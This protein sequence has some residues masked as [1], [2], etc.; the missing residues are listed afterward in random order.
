MLHL[1]E[2]PPSRAAASCAARKQFAPAIGKGVL[3]LHSR[4]HPTSHLCY[5]HLRC[6]N[7]HRHRRCFR[8][9]SRR[10][11]YVAAGHQ[12]TITPS[13]QPLQVSRPPPHPPL[14]KKQLRRRCK[15]EQKPLTPP[16]SGAPAVSLGDPAARPHR[17]S[18]GSTPTGSRS[19]CC[20]SSCTERRELPVP[21]P[22]YQGS[23]GD[24]MPP[25][26]SA[27]TKHTYTLERERDLDPP[28]SGVPSLTHF[29]RSIHHTEPGIMSSTIC[30]RAITL[31]CFMLRTAMTA[32]LVDD[33][34]YSQQLVRNEGAALNFIHPFLLRLAPPYIP[35]MTFFHRY[36][37]GSDCATLAPSA[38]LS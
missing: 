8:R 7:H 21:R 18:E 9:P 11:C 19:R 38:K 26:I 5:C 17:R 30:E 20:G 29:H 32:I 31:T 4:V 15:P 22:S 12:P 10:C 27:T 25:G 13:L 3:P 34:F 2:Q 24:T 6:G 1:R 16:L 35:T 36:G 37:G 23:V 28:A 33:I 14:P